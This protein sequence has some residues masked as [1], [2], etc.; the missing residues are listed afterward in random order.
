[1][2]QRLQEDIACILERDPAAR[3]RWEV[4]TCYPGLHALVLHRW[5]HRAWKREWFWAGRFISHVARFLTGIEIHPGATIGHRVFIDH[6]MGVVIG[7]MAEIHDDCT[8]YQ[9]VTLGGTSLVRGAKRHPTLE[10]GVIVGA[11]ACVLGGFTIGAGARVGSG[12]VVTKPVPAGATAVGN[13]A[14][15]IEAKA[16]AAREEAAGR[17]GFSAYG[18]SQGD[19]PVAQAMRGLIDNAATSS[20]Q[21]ALLWA[22]LDKLTRPGGDTCVPGDAKTTEDFDAEGLNRLVK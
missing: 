19:D 15:I 3:S 2:F 12:A 16:D 22:A 14:R 8:I 10:R 17:M 5:A 18:I 20:H 1:M 6:G 13:P 9:G 7:Q 21:I 11:H 4:L